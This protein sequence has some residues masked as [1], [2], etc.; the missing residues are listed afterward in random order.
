MKWTGEIDIPWDEFREQGADKRIRDGVS[1][2]VSII[3]EN[4]NK[5]EKQYKG[6][7]K[8]GNLRKKCQIYK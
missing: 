5:G 6:E 3:R 2:N 7:K 4:S 8:K 1:L